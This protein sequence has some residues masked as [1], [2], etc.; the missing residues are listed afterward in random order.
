MTH[1]LNILDIC[2][3]PGGAVNDDR[4]GGASHHAW[5]ID[6]ATDVCE[7]PLMPGPSDAAWFAGCLDRSLK[8]RDGRALPP[9]TQL[10][11]ELTG[12]TFEL[13][14]RDARRVPQGRHEH[15]SAAG[16]VLH[17]QGE[18]INF[19][20]LGDCQLFLNM[21]GEGPREIGIDP[22]LARADARNVQFMR[23]YRARSGA[24]TW[25]DVRQSLWP[26]IRQARQWLNQPG[27]YGVFSIT[28]PPAQFVRHGQ[29]GAPVGTRL[30]LAS[31]GF[32]RLA[33][34][35]KRYRA[36]DLLDEASRR[37]LPDL[38]AELRTIEEADPDCLEF[39]RTKP[40][41]DASA[42]LAEIV[43]D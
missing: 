43:P 31:D 2:S 6:G 26:R 20:S 21:P 4:I 30:L 22:A 37:G 32:T 19:L 24:G 17:L 42:L 13:F 12:E 39:P 9:L 41:D 29:L 15:P 28:M 34:I 11:D 10:L 35:F 25:Q 3:S 14:Q 8:G 18:H 5:V 1:R 7:S 27:G 38:V 40:H 36:P 33:D 16:V 23:E